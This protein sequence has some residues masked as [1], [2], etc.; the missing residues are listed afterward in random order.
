MFKRMFILFTLS[1][2]L[3]FAGCGGGG[4][5]VTGKIT[6]PDGTPLERGR[7]VFDSGSQTFYGEVAP[8]GTYTM[9]GGA[10]EKRIPP[11]TYNVYLMGTVLPGDP[12]PEAV[13]TDADGNQIGPPRRELPDIPLV[14]AKYNRTDTSGLQCVVSGKTVFDITVERP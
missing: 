11:G 12:N 2:S 4:H 3:M 5:A 9:L 13:P 8:D 10:G 14:A 1:F 7:V 6:F